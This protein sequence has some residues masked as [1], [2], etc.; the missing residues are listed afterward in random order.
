ME[1]RWYTEAVIYA[2]D[3]ETYAD[4]NGDG[5][6]D[7]PG[8]VDRIDYLSRLGVTCLWLNPVHPTPGRD[9]G[10]DITDFYG[11]E[12]T[13]GSHGDFAEFLYRAGNR[14]IKVILDLV[15]NHTSDQHPWFQSARSSPDSPYRDWYVW[16]TDEP[17][18]RRQGMVFPGEQTETWTWSPEAG[19]WYYHRFYDFQ[20]DLNFA[21]PAVREEIK[22]VLAFWLRL[23]V[24]GFRIDALPFVIELTEPGNPDSPKDYDFVT[25][26]RQL[27]QWRSGDALLLAEANVEPDRLRDYFTDG[28][29]SNNRVHMLF[30]FMLNGQLALAL[31]RRDAEPIVAALR[32]TPQLP[33]GG[34]WATFLRN[35]DEIDLSRLTAKQR[36]DTFAVFG[37]RKNMRLY[38]RGIRRRLAPM[39]GNDR[40]RLELAYSLQFTLR[41][42]PVLRYGDE[43]GMGENLA[44]VGR[45]AI[46]TPMQWADAPNA[47]FSTAPA[48][49]LCRPVISRGEYGYQTVNVTDQ[50][51]DPGSLLSWF[52]RMIHTLK[53][54]PEIGCGRCSHVDLDLPPGVLVHLAEGTT[55]RMLFLHNL[56]D[57]PQKVHVGQLAGDADR[58][59]EV[60]ADQSYPPPGDLTALELGTYGYRWIRLARTPA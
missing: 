48:K 27:V 43:I 2:C 38:D 26:L 4:S 57:Q 53:E 16:S 50:R 10:Y 8:L 23:G 59:D 30:D 34:Q 32:D 39:L 55:G 41:G 40:A 56:D 3:V 21:N 15:V 28:G 35:H 19:A 49:D 24:A 18:D 6:G 31:A 20:P 46:R 12:P 51:H 22:K 45:N 44:L 11:I 54:S 60:F 36:Q 52:E 42:T 1:P 25:E 14:G 37:P 47:G 17:S 5:I 9:D 33:E 13:L 29:G 58:I 7:F